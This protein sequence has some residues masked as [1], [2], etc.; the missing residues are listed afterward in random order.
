VVER[1]AT[2]MVEARERVSACAQCGFLAEAEV[3]LCAICRDGRRD[4]SLLCV[5][6]DPKDV[7]ALEATNEFRGVYHVLGRALSPIDGV[8]P[9]ALRLDLLERRLDAGEVR[10]VILA[11]DPDVEGEATAM[12]L[13]HWLGGR[14]VRVTR[15]ARGLPMGGDLDYA[16]ALTLIR[17]LEGRQDMAGDGPGLR[18]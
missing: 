6:E 3:G 7:A 5:V 18:A 10:E 4:R 13:S 15:I 1:L 2:A 17:A 12:Y 9:E 8:G 14:P 16:D 11:T